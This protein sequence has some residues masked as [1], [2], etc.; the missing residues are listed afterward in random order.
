M[1]TMAPV[2]SSIA[3]Q[4]LQQSNV[5]PV[6]KEEPAT[7]NVLLAAANDV[8]NPTVSDAQSRA[9]AKVSES[10]FDT[11]VDAQQMKIHLYRRLGELL[12]VDM[13][14]YADASDYTKALKEAVQD[15]KLSPNGA[16]ILDELEKELG[17]D[18]LGI[19]IDEFISAMD[20][21]DG[22]AG[23]KLNAA[24]EPALD[25][26]GKDG[27]GKVGVDDLGLYSP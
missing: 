2:S 4:I 12:G 26:D 25:K 1:P 6:P 3:L 14:S 10:L 24:L 18:D 9:K 5:P 15:I 16:N 22:E 23:K 11:K 13:D 19:S 27:P 21:P 7:G 20:D 8:E 17:L